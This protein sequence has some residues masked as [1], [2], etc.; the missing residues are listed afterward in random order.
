MTVDASTLQEIAKAVGDLGLISEGEQFA[1]SSLSGGVSCDVFLVEMKRRPPIVV[2]RALPKLRVEADWRAP[3]ERA[4]SEVAWIEL[5]AKVDPRLVPKVIAQNP[6]QHLFVM[7]YLSKEKYPVWKAQLAEGVVDV[8]F[9]AAVG[10]WL[11][12]IHSVTANS[13]EIA[14]RFDYGAQFMALRLDAYLLHA[15][16][17]NPDVAKRLGE[18]VD[19]VVAARIALMQGDI[20]PKNILHGPETPVFLDAETTCYG[21]PAFDLAFCLN[22]LLL[23]SMWH[24][25]HISAYG[26]GFRELARAYLAGVTWED[27]ARIEARA[28]ALL[29]GLLLARVDGK[30]PVEYIS[31]ARDK[32]FVREHAKKFLRGSHSLEETATEWTKAVR[33]YF[34]ASGSR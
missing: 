31:D 21:D 6:A 10:R 9:A 32:A 3:V 7:A 18:L 24:P 5:V 23:K 2:K 26:E 28:S 4:E 34:T 15:G 27:A 11:A 14:R 17:A 22:H 8:P 13:A 12:L 25:A 19:G 20:S 33:S 30:S 29:A 16:R 1:I